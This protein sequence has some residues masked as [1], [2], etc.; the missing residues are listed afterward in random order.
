MNAVWE[1]INQVREDIESSEIRPFAL[2]FIS[3]H[4]KVTGEGR[5]KTSALHKFKNAVV[6]LIRSRR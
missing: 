4:Y 3:T 1:K 5:H 2:D 6:H